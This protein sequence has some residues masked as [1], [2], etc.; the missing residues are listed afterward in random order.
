MV[1]SG[2]LVRLD[3]LDVSPLEVVE[4]VSVDKPLS[5]TVSR[6]GHFTSSSFSSS[7]SLF[8]SAA[9]KFRAAMLVL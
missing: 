7:G 9:V 8:T 5:L 3:A 1:Q 2:F 6:Q 4:D